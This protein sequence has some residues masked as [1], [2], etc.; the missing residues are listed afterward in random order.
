MNGSIRRHSGVGTRRVAAVGVLGTGGLVV[1]PEPSKLMARVQIPAGA[2]SVEQSETKIITGILNQRAV[3]GRLRPR[4]ANGIAVSDRRGRVRFKS[5]PVRCRT[6]ESPIT[7]RTR[8]FSPLPE[9]SH[10]VQSAH[11]CRDSHRSKPR[12]HRSPSVVDPDSEP[13]EAARAPLHSSAG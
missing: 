13:K 6:H 8:A 10:R 3:R 11:R 9:P 5:R 2:F 7:S 12:V 1:G 4:K